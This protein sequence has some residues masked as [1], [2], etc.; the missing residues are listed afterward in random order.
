MKE[1]HRRHPSCVCGCLY[2]EIQ[3]SGFFAGVL[4]ETRQNKL[5]SC[6]IKHAATSNPQV[7]VLFLVPA[8]DWRVPGGARLGA[9]D[10]FTAGFLY[11]M[12]RGYPLQQAARVGCLAGG[13][14]VQSLGAG[15]QQGQLALAVFQAR[16]GTFLH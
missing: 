7:I 1:H 10:L 14:V 11:G 2:E 6:P 12:L 16:P 8:A 13:A 15:A 5:Y 4:H 9:G 3:E